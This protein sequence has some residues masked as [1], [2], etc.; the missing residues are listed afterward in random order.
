MTALAAFVTGRRTKWLV[1]VLW[2]VAVAALAPLAAKVA[3]VTSD[4]TASFLAEARIDAS[5]GV[6]QGSVPRWRDQHRSDRLPARGRAHGG[7][8]GE[9]RARRTRRGPARSRS[10]QP[11]P[12]VPFT[13]GAPPGLVSPR[14]DTAYTV[15]TV[16]LDFDRVAD[17]GTEAREVIGGSRGGLE[18]YVTG[19]LGLWADF[20][21]VFEGLDEKL[22]F[23]TVILVL[24][25]LLLIYRAP[26]IAITPVLVVGS[27]TV[28]TGVVYLLAKGGLHVD[29]Q[30]TSI[31]AVLMFGAGTDY[32]LLL[33]SGY[34]EE[35][36]R[37]EDKHEAMARAVRRAGPAIVASGLTVVGAL[38]TMLVA[39][40]GS[41]RSLG[42]IAAIGVFTVMIASL[43]LLPCLLVIFGRRGFWPRRR[44]IAYDP[45]GAI[46]D[47]SLWRRFGLRVVQ[48][49]AL[50]LLGSSAVLG[51]L[52]LGLLSP[53]RRT[54]TS[55][56]SSGSEPESV[57]GFEVLGSRSPPGA[58]TRRRSWSP[59]QRG[60]DDGPTARRP[61]SA[62]RTFDGSPRCEPA[63]L[64]GR[65]DRQDRR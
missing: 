60:A 40:L 22:L 37:I 13:P 45:E 30:G 43:T 1:I 7:R 64:R 24:V 56:R 28:A 61:P 50:A 19:D 27:P 41:T 42:P 34:R 20:E 25:L 49:P 46:E 51:V 48:R 3:D 23:A 8:Q 33:V 29:S 63:S 10:P 21:E 62:C 44:L 18:V 36:R 5:P 15:V 16:P 12:Q 4:E 14:G 58:S 65:R 59:E 47:R 54:S 35:L 39:D 9:D 6:A 32:C 38:L 2:I 31:L 17:W 11:V 52:C 53:T 26:L 57:D 55:T